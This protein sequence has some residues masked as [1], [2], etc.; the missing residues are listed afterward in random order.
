MVQLTHKSF[1][2]SLIV[3]D[4]W[5]VDTIYIAV[6]Y[7]VDMEVFYFGAMGMLCT[8]M[9][10]MVV[11]HCKCTKCHRIGHSKMVNFILCVFHLDF[12]F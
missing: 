3:P 11:P 12:F 1:S 2:T 7:L 6:H 10:M 9:E 4:V 8:L 5:A